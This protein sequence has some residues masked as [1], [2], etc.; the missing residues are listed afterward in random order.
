MAPR[1]AHKGFR[2]CAET[3]EKYTVSLPWPTGPSSWPQ[4]PFKRARIALRGPEKFPR[5]PQDG[6][7]RAKMA[8]RGAQKSFKRSP[9]GPFLSL[10]SWALACFP[11]V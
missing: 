8:P 9:R 7:Q 2:K 4:D 3:A 10:T 6:I 11:K 1:G 5:W